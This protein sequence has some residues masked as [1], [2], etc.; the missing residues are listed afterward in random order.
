MTDRRACARTRAPGVRARVRHGYR[1]VVIDV[2]PGG[3]LVEAGGPLRPG[4]HVE[5][6]LE[7]NGRK[8][9]CAA[10]VV[11]CDVWAISASSGTTYRAGLA[12][13]EAC[14]WVCEEETPV[15]CEFP[16]EDAA[17]RGVPVHD[18]PGTAGSTETMCEEGLK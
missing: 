16:A 11:R 15:V 9:W 4:A 3:A 18:V 2:S 10:R 14:G 5:L 13:S 1:L 6:Q 17:A 8:E 12:F 7:T